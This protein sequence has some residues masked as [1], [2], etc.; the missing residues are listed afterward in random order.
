MNNKILISTVI[1]P[2]VLFANKPAIENLNYD[3]S[4][5][6][7]KSN[8]GKR[9]N[10]AGSVSIPIMNYIGIRLN[11]G[12]S[13]LNGKDNYLDSENKF[14]G[15]SLILRDSLI[16]KIETSYK[17]TLSDTDFES[18]SLNSKDKQLSVNATYYFN[19]FDFLV[20]RTYSKST[21][22]TDS[23]NGKSIINSSTRYGTYMNVAYYINDNLRV[24]TGKNSNQSY[25]TNLSISYQPEILNNS[26]ILSTS[27]NINNKSYNFGLK[28]TFNTRVNLKDRNRK[29]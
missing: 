16:G 4:S 22:D 2:I 29:Y 25:K 24:L 27:Y 19:N 20:N 11:T 12:L 14:A 6:Y 28:Y 9:I 26:M 3:I 23:F 5:N 15:I 1:L 17:Y 7:N 18:I 8:I 10:I 13:S 21:Y